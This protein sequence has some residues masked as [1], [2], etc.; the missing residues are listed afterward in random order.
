MVLLPLYIPLGYQH[1]TVWL[2]DVVDTSHDLYIA[3]EGANSQKTEV[4][5]GPQTAA[6]QHQAVKTR[7]PENGD[8]IG[9]LDAD[10]ALQVMCLYCDT[11]TMTVRRGT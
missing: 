1:I 3:T 7:P 6:T 2:A 10:E 9:A 4:S 5:L 8:R 11:P